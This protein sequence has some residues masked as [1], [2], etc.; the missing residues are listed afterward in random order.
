MK[1][2]I[3]YDGSDS[4]RIALT[5]AQKQAKAMNAEIYMVASASSVHRDLEDTRNTCLEASLRDA[6]I[7]YIEFNR[8]IASCAFI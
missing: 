1:L 8:L 3:G 6:Q 7:R 2:L 5:A 4:A